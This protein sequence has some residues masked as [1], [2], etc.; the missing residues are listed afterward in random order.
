MKLPSHFN[1]NIKMK[2]QLPTMPF[3]EYLVVAGKKASL[4]RLNAVSQREGG[5][6]KSGAGDQD[7]GE[8]V[9]DGLNAKSME[10]AADELTKYFDA[11][12]SCCR[13]CCRA[14]DVDV[15]VLIV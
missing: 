11:M 8:K 2:L 5:G 15:A 14:V 10:A 4:K 7:A 12:V 1:V 13:S 6:T 9:E 3:V